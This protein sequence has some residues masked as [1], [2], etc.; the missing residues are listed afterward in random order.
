MNCGEDI[1]QGVVKASQTGILLSQVQ[2]LWAPLS[3]AQ[4][5]FKRELLRD[6]S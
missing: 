1:A 3:K 2:L 6:F 4:F 5:S